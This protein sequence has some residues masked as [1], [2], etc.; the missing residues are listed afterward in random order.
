MVDKDQDGAMELVKE[1][2]R[3]AW[4]LHKVG[5]LFGGGEPRTTGKQG[6]L[7]LSVVVA[8]GAGHNFGSAC[9]C[10]SG[11]GEAAIVGEAHLAVVCVW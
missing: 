11:G 10:G 7:Y 3:K 5:C 8:G 6:D 4:A 9:R 2:A 1:G